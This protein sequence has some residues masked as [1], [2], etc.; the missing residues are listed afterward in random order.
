MILIIVAHP[1]DE[2]FWFGGTIL[3]L[4]N[5]GFKITIICLTGG[6]DY[7]RS[8]E[9]KDACKKMDVV[10]FILNYAD[11]AD[12][13]LSD[14]AS[15]LKKISSQN[16]ILM[17]NIDCVITHA[18]HGNERGHPQHKQCFEM[19]KNWANSNNIPLGFYSELL[20]PELKLFR[21]DIVDD[22]IITFSNKLTI[23]KII[24]GFF[25]NLI[26]NRLSI[27][28]LI[29]KI[30]LYDKLRK[31]NYLVSFKIDKKKKNKLLVIYKSQLEGLEQY[32]T[33]AKDVEYLFVDRLDVIKKI[34]NKYAIYI[35]KTIS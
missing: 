28:T 21:K 5:L 6:N 33:Y 13:V 27:S 12:N 9:F 31:F 10:G 29:K 8:Q 3:T 25:F 30:R 14:I 22:N 26:N 11:E 7:L 19:V 24:R 18:P 15:N 2:S 23:L 20:Y 16:K 35:K 17:K 4:R 32:D 1:D 34:K